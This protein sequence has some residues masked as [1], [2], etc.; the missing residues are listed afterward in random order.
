MATLVGAAGYIKSNPICTSGGIYMVND[1][2]TQPVC[3][4][5]AVIPLDRT[6]HHELP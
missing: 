2:A 6:L 1:L 4:L 3:S 5:G